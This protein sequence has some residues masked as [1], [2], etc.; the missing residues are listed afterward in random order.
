MTKTDIKDLLVY[1]WWLIVPSLGF[2]TVLMANGV[3][4]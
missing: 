3:I 1:A 2:A 4:G